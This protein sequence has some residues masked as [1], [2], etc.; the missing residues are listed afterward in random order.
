[1]NS[2]E[3][4]ETIELKID[5]LAYG[6]EG[7]A[8]SEGKVYFVNGA[9]PG[10]KVR[11]EI[12]QD[13]KNFAR[14]EIVEILEPSKNRVEPPCDY[15]GHCGGCQL[16]H[17]AYEEQLVWK[18]KW[19][20]ELLSRIGNLKDI[21]IDPVVASPKPYAYRNRVGLTL[22]H[23]GGGKIRQGFL[24]GD[25]RGLVDID[26]CQIAM[27]GINQA[28][29]ELS[30]KN[31]MKNMFGEF[32]GRLKLEIVT[33][34]HNTFFLPWQSL[35][36]KSG[37]GTKPEE[38]KILHEKVGSLEFEFSPNVFFQVNSYLLPR[39]LDSVGALLGDAKDACLF[40]LFSGV[41][42]FG[43]SLSDRVKKVVGLEENKLAHQFAIRN[44]KRNKIENM[45]VYTGRVESQFKKIFMK[46]KADKNIILV[47]PPR[48]GVEASL[49]ENF[50]EFESEIDSIIY[51]SCEPS[52]L[53]RDLARFQEAG[54]LPERILPFDLFPQTQIFETVVKLKRKV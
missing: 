3:T 24:S 19:L 48:G 50:K 35:D 28:I 47:D 31:K 36:E 25:D 53:A 10:E 9:L 51:L 49:I 41:G 7:V 44:I 20:E 5:S 27:P 42:L 18:Q 15:Y 32:E 43:M 11:A 21:T 16:Q 13:K 1:M 34:G 45:Y 29:D 40:D 54:F 39:L 30:R 46:Q 12:V 2:S 17:L 33:D 22:A 23:A 8:R 38:G 14:A 37:R 26:S 6:G 52:I 4:P